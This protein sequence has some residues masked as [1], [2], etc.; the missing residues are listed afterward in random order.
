MNSID[1]IGRKKIENLVEV[2]NFRYQMMWYLPCLATLST[3]S[4]AVSF[5]TQI[6]YKNLAYEALLKK[7]IGRII[8]FLLGA[9]GQPKTET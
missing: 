8:A 6:W 2:T 9:M 5:I 7:I 1:F 4:D 3:S